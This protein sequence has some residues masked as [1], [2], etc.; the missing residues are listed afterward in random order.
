MKLAVVIPTYGRKELVTRTLGHLARQTL[1]PDA[2]LVSA[3]DASH[4]ESRVPAGLDYVSFVFGRRGLVAQRNQALTKLAGAYDI[5][6]FF[7]DDFLPAADYLAN[8][9]AAFVS[10][11]DWIVLTGDVVRDGINDAGVPFRDAEAQLAALPAMA[12]AEGE[13]QPWHGGYGCNMAVRMSAIG[14]E[15][16]D[17]RLVLYGWQEDTDFTRRVARAGGIIRHTA[18]RG[19]HLGT[20]G[21]RVSGVRL[22]YS[23]IVNPVYLARKG[24]VTRGMAGGLIWR[25]VAANLAKSF[26]PEPWVDRRGRLK[27]NLIGAVHLLRGRVEPEYASEL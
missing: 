6:C 21:G 26:W 1:K 13:A 14:A 8:T 16:F 20:K 19:I 2:V 9:V 11:P 22:G 4:V 10:H 25:N 27:G 12:L 3:P 24:S 17:E 5:V 23:Q 15:Q 18:L 7:D